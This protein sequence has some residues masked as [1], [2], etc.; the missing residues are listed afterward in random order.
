MI[1]EVASDSTGLRE[2]DC[3]C[4][5]SK[6][7]II[8]MK[9]NCYYCR[10]G[11]DDD[12]EETIPEEKLL[13]DS[14]DDDDEKSLSR[15]CSI[16]ESDDQL[17]PRQNICWYCRE[18]EFEEKIEELK[19]LL[20]A[21]D[22]IIQKLKTTATPSLR[23]VNYSDKSFAVYGDTKPFYQDFKFTC[24]G[25]WNQNLKEGPGWIFQNKFRPQ[26]EAIINK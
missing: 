4:G 6:D 13:S 7:F 3:P 16:C 14:D 5:R 20:K 26:V 9:K 18:Q 19:K 8:Q 15:V 1:Q 22:E 17:M 24:R 21:K 10:D 11:K 12:D 25:L 2:N 23:I